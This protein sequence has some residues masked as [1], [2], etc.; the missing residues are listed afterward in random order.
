MKIIIKCTDGIMTGKEWRFNGSG[1]ITLGREKGSMV[2][3]APEDNSISRHQCVIDVVPPNVYVSDAGSTHGTYV[4]GQLIGKQGQGGQCPVRDGAFIGVGSGGRAAVF[5]IRIIEEEAKM[6]PPSYVAGNRENYYN[7]GSNGQ[8]LG[9]DFASSF[10]FVVPRIRD[11]FIRPVHTAIEFGKMNSAVLGTTMILINMA[12]LLVLAVLVMAIAKDKL[13]G[14]GAYVPWG[15]IIFAVELMAAFSYFGLA[16]LMLLSARVFFR[17]EIT[18]AQLLSFY[19]VQ[20]IWSTA[21]LLI[22]SLLLMIGT[23]GSIML[24]LLVFWISI[25][26]TFLIGIFSYGEVVH[27]SPDKKMYSYFVFVIL[28]VITYAIILYILGSGASSALMQ[29]SNP[30][31]LW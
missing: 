9:N 8:N 4:N 14:L 6:V 30:T 16:A 5:Q 23:E 29:F 18:Y 21:Y 22:E 10:Q 11:I 31:S 27:L 2:T 17:A 12:V 20:A 1:Q 24:F 25:I 19:G 13:F 7:R 28:Y 3:T 15:R 26:H